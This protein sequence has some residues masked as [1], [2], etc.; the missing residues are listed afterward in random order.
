M[1]KFLL[2]KSQKLITKLKRKVQSEKER[3]IISEMREAQRTTRNVNRESLT[4]LK[5]AFLKVVLK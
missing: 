2:N 5:S 1:T 3:K 4:D